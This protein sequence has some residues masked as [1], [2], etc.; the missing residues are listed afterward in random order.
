MPTSPQTSI[1]AAVT[2]ALPGPT[3]RSTGSRPASGS[4]YARAPIACAPPATT[5]ASTSSRPAAP[6]RTG[7]VRAIAVGGRRDDDL[8]DA[9]DLGR[10]DGH[11]QR[12]R[13]GRRAAR[14]VGADARERGPAPLDLDAGGD[15]GATRGG[16][17]G[18]GEA[19]DVVDRLVERATDARLEAVA[20]VAQVG[21]VEDEAAVG[22]ATTDG[23][24]RVTDRGVA[25]FANVG[26]GR[27]G[28]P[29]GRVGRGPR[30]AGSGR[31][32]SRRASGSPA[33]TAARSRRCRRS[34]AATSVVGPPDGA[35]SGVTASADVG[36]VALTGRSS[37]SAGP[38]SP[39]RRQP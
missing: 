39:M 29:R 8:G 1:L 13:V 25:T 15:R 28:R 37:R 7:F 27:R 4:P 34:G 18:L 30:R 21:R 2:Q 3:I 23:R 26:E 36:R 33:A 16:S 5:K 10:D 17:L 32:C 9:R 22:A 6:R 19:A 38:G 20:R 11:D 24:V 12:R 14:D 31:R 35:V